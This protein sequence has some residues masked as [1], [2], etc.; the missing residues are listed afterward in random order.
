MLHLWRHAGGMF[1]VDLFFVLSGFLITGI[2]LDERDRTG[3]F[4]LQ[5]FYKR[6][7]VRLLPPLVLMLAIVVPLA[8]ISTGRPSY[9]LSSALIGLSYVTNLALVIHP[10]WVESN[11]A[12]LWSLAAEEQFYLVWPPLLLLLWRRRWL[13]VALVVAA[14]LSV[15][16]YFWIA[17]GPHIYWQ[18]AGPDAHAA[19]ILLGCAAAFIHRRAVRIPSWAGWGGVIGAGALVTLHSIH[20]G[21]DGYFAAFAAF[22]MLPILHLAAGESIL[23]RLFSIRPLRYVGRISYSLY[24]WNTPMLWLFGGPSSI[25]WLAPLAL[26]FL[27]AAASW[28]YMESPLLRR[29]SARTRLPRVLP[30]V[31]AG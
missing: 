22:A 6:R 28:R 11:F 13:P 12:H 23:S 24:L 29:H 14:G 19:P 5:A 27:L 9:E 30:A 26:S 17:A 31:A 20:P 15:A 18:D 2:L 7:A 1:G 25:P 21:A 3:S 4:N 8:S 10:A 16:D